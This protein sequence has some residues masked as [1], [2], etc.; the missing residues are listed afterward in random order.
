M[1]SLAAVLRGARL[2]LALTHSAAT[3]VQVPSAWRRQAVPLFDGAVAA[4]ADLAA[5]LAPA[6]GGG[7]FAGYPL[8]VTLGDDCVRLFMVPPLAGAAGLPDIRAAAAMRFHRLYG[9]DPG[10]WQIETAP[11]ADRPFLACALPTALSGAIR[12]AARAHG[13]RLTAVTPLF[14]LTWNQLNRRIGRAWLGVVQED[15]ITLGCVDGRPKPD[16]AAVHRLRLPAGACSPAWLR[17]QVRAV[18]LRHGLEE[19]SDLKLFG[20]PLG[21]ASLPSTVEGLTL[22]RLDPPRVRP[23]D[24]QVFIPILGPQRRTG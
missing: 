14:V 13:L 4:D 1:R 5:A 23:I 2:H 20:A 12:S 8:S 19:P 18:A 7:R 22:S 15:S 3:L 16:L 11:S 24:R 6:L 9:D 21:G 10:G 17:G